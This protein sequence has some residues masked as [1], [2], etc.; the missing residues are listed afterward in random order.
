[1]KR[2]P[3]APAGCCPEHQQ[4]HNLSPPTP[5][6][7]CS[8]DRHED[9]SFG[10]RRVEITCSNCGGHLGH[11]FEGEGESRR[12]EGQ[13]GAGGVT[14]ARV[15]PASLSIYHSTSPLLQASPRPRISATAST[16]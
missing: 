5:A 11:V 6:C 9:N 4:W 10:M 7:P 13:A 12:G 2:S 15:R 1:M 16:H 3:K 8:V 14:C